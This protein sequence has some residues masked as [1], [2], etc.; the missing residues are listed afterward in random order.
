MMAITVRI[1]II[2]AAVVTMIST[3]PN[4]DIGDD[5]ADGVGVDD[6]GVGIGVLVGVVVGFGVGVEVGVG[7]GDGVSV[8]VAI[9]V[10][11]G[12]AVIEGFTTN[13]LLVPV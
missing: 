4:G 1:T 13:E 5:V 3:S 11:V 8:G 10:G 2:S 9:G 12:V 7:E 6:D